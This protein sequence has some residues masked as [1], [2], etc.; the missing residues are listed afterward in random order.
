[1][2]H[3]YV[4]HILIAWR[5]ASAWL[6]WV[7]TPAGSRSG[8][9]WAQAAHIELRWH[10][11]NIRNVSL[12]IISPCHGGHVDLGAAPRHVWLTQAARWSSDA[13]SENIW[14]KSWN[15]P[16]FVAGAS[17][18]LPGK[19]LESHLSFSKFGFWWGTT[20]LP[21]LQYHKTNTI[22]HNDYKEDNIYLK[23]H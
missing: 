22:L 20:T 6:I 19:H 15:F 23:E 3:H 17:P 12:T 8:R 16:N 14:W 1:M 4:S 2:G 10:N 5:D 21:S 9:M 18:R 13:W 11:V 7:P